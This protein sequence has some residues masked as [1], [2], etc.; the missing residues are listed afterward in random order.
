MENGSRH[1][2][3]LKTH[4]FNGCQGHCPEKNPE[5]GGARDALPRSHLD[6]EVRCL[7]H[8]LP[9]VFIPL[10]KVSHTQMLPGAR[11]VIQV[12]Q[13]GQ[14]EKYKVL[15]TSLSFYHLWMD[16][17]YEETFLHYK[18]NNSTSVMRKEVINTKP[19]CW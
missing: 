3:G 4:C 9:C 12:C 10:V 13:M 17:G 16:Y 2:S 18:K 7:M 11:Q 15:S 8:L 1:H 5:Q 6:A 14:V 19:H